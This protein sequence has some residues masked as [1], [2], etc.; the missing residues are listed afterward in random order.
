WDREKLDSDMRVTPKPNTQFQIVTSDS[1]S[2]KASSLG[3]DAALKASFLSGLV[4][5]QGS[6]KY[7]NDNKSSRKQAR[8]TLQYKTTTVFKELT[9]N[10]LGRDNIKHHEV[11]DKGLATHVVSAILYGAQAFFVFDQE[12]SEDEQVQD[13]KGNLKVMIQKIPMISI[14]EVGALKMEA[15][16]R[17]KVSKFSCTFHGDFSLDKS[18]TTF[19]ESVKLYQDLPKL[20][21]SKGENA[22][23]V[24]V[25][26]LPLSIL[27]SRASKLVRQISL[28]LISKAESIL[29]NFS[30]L[31]MRCNDVL[32]CPAGQNF[33][34]IS[35]KVKTFNSLYSEFRL[36][37]QR[38]LAEKLPSIRGGGEEEATLAAV[39]NKTEESPFSSH[40]LNQWMD[41]VVQEANTINALTNLMKNTEIIS[42]EYGLNEK[43]CDP[44]KALVFVFT[45]LERAEQYLKELENHLEGIQTIKS[46]TEP[47]PWYRTKE[48]INQMRLKAKVFGDFAETNKDQDRQ[49][50][51]FLAVGFTDENHKDVTIRLYE[52]GFLTCENF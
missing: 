30:E 39:L 24:M 23:P 19:E 21:G 15:R 28:R 43:V 6:A 10:Q 20:L 34:H 37:L 29:E 5:V 11:I 3:V 7:L 52:D 38:A 16:D 45:S 2:E 14:D 8:V 51:R 44:E 1:V 25:H 13:I 27:E 26:L 36:G 22:V 41:E 31:D 12:T 4:N 18:P 33:S 47:K 42:S 50:L 40:R 9:M 46:E 48:V 32:K 35:K 17:E 49:H